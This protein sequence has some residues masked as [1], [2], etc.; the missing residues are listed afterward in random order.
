M[1]AAPALELRGVVKRYRGGERPA[2]D[3]VDLDVAAAG[4]LALLGPNGA[5]KSTLVSLAA[6]LLAPD[7]GTVRVLGADPAARAGAAR[8]KIGVAP[9]EIGVYPQLTV[10]ANLRCFAEL[11]GM[12]PRAAQI[13]RAHV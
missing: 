13:G 5:G 8:R 2:L 3:G 4:V 12:A 7:A 9:Q 11:Y 1:S 10:S 6:G